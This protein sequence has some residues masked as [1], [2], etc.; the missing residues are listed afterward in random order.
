MKQIVLDRKPI[1]SDSEWNPKF[2]D[3]FKHYGFIPRLCRPYRPQTKGKIESTVKFVKNDF[4][5]GGKFSSFTDLNLQLQQWLSRVNSS[6]HGT[7]HEIPAERLKLEAFNKI[8]EVRPYIVTRKNPRKISSD[9]H[10]SYLGNKYSVHINLEGQPDF[11]IRDTTFSV[12]VGNE[13]VCRHEI[14]PG[15][16]KVSRNQDHFKGLLS[17]ILKQNS[18]FRIKRREYHPF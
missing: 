6:I 15:H 4:F 10:L 3:F 2:E 14:L 13:L 17:E 12:F 5:M 11:Q 18:A 9:S 1:S 8:S 16:G 7:T